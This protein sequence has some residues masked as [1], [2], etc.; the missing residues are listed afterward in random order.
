MAVIEPPSRYA[1]HI[2]N[3]TDAM[4]TQRHNEERE[5]LGIRHIVRIRRPQRPSPPIP[6]TPAIPSLPDLPDLQEGMTEPPRRGRGRPPT[7]FP[8]P[9]SEV[10]RRRMAEIRRTNTEEERAILESIRDAELLG[11][12]DA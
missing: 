3:I 7:R 2:Q 12:R 11:Y 10:E 6:S 9:A 8:V 4:E 5:R 1:E